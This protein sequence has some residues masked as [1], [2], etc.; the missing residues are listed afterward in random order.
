MSLHLY[1]VKH[2]TDRKQQCRKLNFSF[3]ISHRDSYQ[4]T[5]ERLLQIL[6]DV[7]KTNLSTEEK[8]NRRLAAIVAGGSTP[9]PSSRPGSG[10]R[11]RSSGVG[12]ERSDD[13]SNGASQSPP[14][15]LCK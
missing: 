11:R 5:N 10:L 9:R 3:F 8:I 2:R 12:A 15:G 4:E 13:A 7:V 6:S 1:R 14:Q